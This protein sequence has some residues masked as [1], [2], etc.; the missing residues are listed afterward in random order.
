MVSLDYDQDGRLA[1]VTDWAGRS[2][3][4]SYDSRGN[5]SMVTDPAGART[6]YRY[7]HY[8]QLISVA[9]RLGNQTEVGL[10]DGK[11]RSVTDPLGNETTVTYDPILRKS[12]ITDPRR[13][14]T[15]LE[16]NEVGSLVKQTDALG[17]ST[18]FQYDDDSNLTQ[19]T[20]IWNNTWEYDYDLAGNMIEG[21]DPP[22]TTTV[23]TY[24]QLNLPL[25]VSVF[26]EPARLTLLAD[27]YYTYDGNGNVLTVS[28]SIGVSQSVYRTSSFA[29]DPVRPGFISSFTDPMGSTV[30]FTYGPYGYPLTQTR[31]LGLPGGGAAAVVSSTVYDMIGNLLSATDPSGN[32]PR[33]STI[34][35]AGP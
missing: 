24:S 12:T 6:V 17:R 22:G 16:Y 5:L 29:Y 14:S 20:D 11:C 3:Q 35:W 1:E 28:E 15:V 34:S 33:T 18:H 23:T 27:L 30:D 9:D 26:S 32:V 10:V 21:R 7:D 25:S 2:V 19:L 4:Y 31:Y 8:R 13:H